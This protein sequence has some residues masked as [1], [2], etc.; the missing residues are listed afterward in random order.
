MNPLFH[1]YVITGYLTTLITIA[2]GVF[3]YFKNRFSPVNR[4][5]LIYSLS[6]A[7]WSFFSA[8]HASLNDPS[9]A[10]FWAKFC[11]IGVL[12]IPVF[13]YYFSLK[14]TGRRN[15]ILLSTGFFLAFLIMLLMFITPY[16]I[17]RTRQDVG[18]PNFVADGPLYAVIILFFGVY[19]SLAHAGIWR[20]IRVSTGSRKK[21][22]QYF[23]WAS[24]LGYGVGAFNFCP[25]YGLITFPFPYSAICGAIYSMICAYA[26]VKHK[27]FDIDLIVKKGLVFGLLFGIVY[28]TASL[29]IYLTSSV[30]SSQSPFLTFGISIALAMAVYEP[31]KKVLIRLT[32]RFL[33]QKKT[34][35]IHLIRNLTDELSET[36]DIHVI[37]N[38]LVTF[39]V[40]EMPLEWAGL[41]LEDTTGVFKLI[42]HQGEPL[43]KELEGT[44]PII[45]LVQQRKSP[46]ILPPFD[47]ESKLEP[48]LKAKL[49]S[50][51][52]EA[53]A[54]I[55]LDNTLSGIILLGK[56]KSDDSFNREDE[57]LLT[58]LV[59]EASMLFLSVK[60][61]KDLKRAN[62]ELGQRKKM[63]ALTQLSRGV[64]HE[65]RNP[66]HILSLTASSIRTMAEEG[67]YGEVPRETVIAKINQKIESMLDD[68][69]RI[70]NS[71]NR[72]ADFA[73]PEKDQGLVSISLKN[74]IDNFLALMEEGQKLD[75]IKVHN[76]VPEGLNI[77]GT[78]TGLQEILFNLFNNS[79]E[80][81]NGC[82]ELLLETREEAG[83]IELEFKDSGPGI[84]KSI[85]PHIFNEY[86]TT[87]TN[88]EAAGI[89]LSIVKHRI[90]L[91]GGSIKAENSPESGAR[92]I[93]RFKKEE[94]SVMAA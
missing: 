70:K 7:E 93:I 86:F 19:V 89:G 31:I 64:H 73:R 16:F 11:H 26:I 90:E 10:L 77:I 71:L 83:F 53:F 8:M 57:A 6:I 39:L 76:L 84:D 42:N 91:F 74:E 56:K 3:V 55:F 44:D 52:V 82:G 67:K 18:I 46:I 80:A 59:D 2:V 51:K 72:F 37:S 60:L 94:E 45:D 63:M 61:L 27:L 14:I 21:H 48:E 15:P 33:Y 28:T 54:P 22:L 79:Y 49:R 13:F 17:P 43:I 40:S 25:V 78:K 62:L 34:A 75:A 4:S 24:V 69:N 58:T 87:K 50:L 38:K 92:F 30:T 32:Q 9:W 12:M 88:S 35:Y 36:R 5:F 81:M 29:L 1:P 85:L 65:V 20:E 23:F 66:L 47:T 41:Y 68:N